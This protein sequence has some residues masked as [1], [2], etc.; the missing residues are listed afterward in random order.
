MT[1]L[2]NAWYVAAHAHELDDGLVSRKICDEPIVMFRTSGGAVAA[3]AD[4]CPHRFV[5]LS[6]GKRVG[7]TLQCGYHGLVFDANGACVGAPNDEQQ[8]ARI[9]VRSYAIVER[10]AL[11]WLWLG[12][13]EQADADLI[14]TFEFVSNTERYAVARGYSHINAQYEFL[15]DNLLDLS[16]VHYLHPGI[17]DGANFADFE[18]KVKVEDDTV[19]S[20]LWRH[21]YRLDAARQKQMDLYADVVD[22]QGHSRW[23]APGNLLVDTGYW[24]KG[25]TMAE[26]LASPSAHLLT[27][28]TEHSTHYFWASGR[29]NDIHNVERTRITEQKMHHIFETQ[30]GPMCE[31]Q[32]I[33]LG[34]DNDF[35]AAR[36]IILRADAAGVAARRILKRKLREEADTGLAD[37]CA[38]PK[39]ATA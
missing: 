25:K 32:Q 15:A 10:Y 27:P 18:N 36:P 19:W 35:L 29:T 13:P 21:D 37:L 26:G 7:D 38:P 3:L 39:R 6:K 5:P 22:G 8:K 20:M 9:C 2:K 11:I 34:G 23:N 12:A 24:E 14:P 28:E 4:R 17:H 1:F 31:A 30:D 33:A 16:H